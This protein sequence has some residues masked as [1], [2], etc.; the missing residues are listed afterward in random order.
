MLREA[1][2]EELSASLYLDQLADGF[3]RGEPIYLL[4]TCTVIKPVE[5]KTLWLLKPNAAAALPSRQMQLVRR[6]EFKP[7]VIGAWHEI[8]WADR[9]GTRVVRSLIVVREEGGNLRRI[10]T[11]PGETL[12]D[13][14]LQRDTFRTGAAAFL[15]TFP[16]CSD[17]K[18]FQVVDTKVTSRRAVGT[19]EEEWTIVMCDKSA[20]IDV[21][22]SPDGP[23]MNPGGTSIVIKAAP[24]R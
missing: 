6:S 22:Y 18:T 10:A 12:A 21:L 13:P 19:W 24:P 14:L 4:K 7:P 20:K 16:G 9:C 11:N 1:D 15:V 17:L 8:W 2:R 23:L 3:Q 5:R